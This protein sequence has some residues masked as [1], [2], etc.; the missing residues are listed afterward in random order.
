MLF[1]GALI[2]SV[3]VAGFAITIH[4]TP[5]ADWDRARTVAFCILSYS[6]LFYSFSCRSD[7]FT[8]P[9]LGMFTN[10]ALIWAILISGLL[11]TAV[12]LPGVRKIFHVEAG[13][14]WEWPMILLLALLPVTVIEI[15]KI[16][17]AKRI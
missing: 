17:K 5:G 8:L 7:R 13:M 15:G 11:Q 9:Q 4:L 6:Q 12:F 2:A 14:T 16:I 10:R 3:T 1:H